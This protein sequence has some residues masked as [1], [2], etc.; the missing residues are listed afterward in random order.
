MKEKAW[1]EI[2][3]EMVIKLSSLT[4]DVVALLLRRLFILRRKVKVNKASFNFRHVSGIGAILVL[5]D[6][7]QSLNAVSRDKK[8][9]SVRQADG[10]TNFNL[11]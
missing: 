2:A 5:D 11:I 9:A 8:L 4:Y 6:S 7:A 1:Q 10:S 3:T